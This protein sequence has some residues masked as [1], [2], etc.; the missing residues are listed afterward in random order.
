MSRLVSYSI[1]LFFIF[2]NPIVNFSQTQNEIVCRG[3]GDLYFN[4]T[5][6]SNFSPQPQIWITFKKANYGVGYQLEYSSTL[7]PG[8]CTF[9]D[10][11]LYNNEP[12]RILI[13]INV[14]DFSISW[15]QGRVTGISSSLTYLNNLQDSNRFQSFFIYNDGRGNFI[16]TSIGQTW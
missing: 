1:F 15:F 9:K 11:G 8:Q 14:N 3:G 7:L 12:N 16:V 5:P 4:Y 10:R 13:K 2:A 6:F